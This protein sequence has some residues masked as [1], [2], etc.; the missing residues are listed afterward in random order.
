MFDHEFGNWK[1]SE[2]V[3]AFLEQWPAE[4]EGVA[5]EAPLTD[6]RFIVADIMLEAHQ[7]LAYGNKIIDE[8]NK[9]ASE[10]SADSKAALEVEFIIDDIKRELA[11]NE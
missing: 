11:C 1:N 7:K 9:I 5:V 4:P 10:L 8:L 3:T 2:V 6:N